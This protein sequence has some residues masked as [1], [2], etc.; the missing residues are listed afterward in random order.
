MDVGNVMAVAVVAS[1]LGAA[2]CAAVAAGLA[3][4]AWVGFAVAAVELLAVSASC[5][6]VLVGGGKGRR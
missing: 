1:A 2:A 5:A 6:R 4:G 3:L